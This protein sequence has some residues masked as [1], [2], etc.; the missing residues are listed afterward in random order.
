MEKP[1]TVLR[2]LRILELEEMLKLS[3]VLHVK[4]VP[5]KKAAGAELIVWDDAESSS[6]KKAPEEEAKILS[7]PRKRL[8]ELAPIP[9][10]KQQVK[11]DI[12]GLN[13]MATDGVL[14]QR[15]LAKHNG[16][17]IHKTSAIKGYKKSTEIYV[18]KTSSDEGK[19]KI[20]FAATNG[21]LVNKKQA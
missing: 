10:E 6:S 13:S 12:P 2:A 16:E 7:F 21:I 14:W 18:V 5:L 17:I 4:Q 1:S 3:E 19:D 9:E 20:R 8:S 11:D 15:E